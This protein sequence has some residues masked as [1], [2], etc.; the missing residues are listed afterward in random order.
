MYMTLMLQNKK[1][2]IKRFAN[3]KGMAT[4]VAA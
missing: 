1:R 4:F 3:Q 2:Y